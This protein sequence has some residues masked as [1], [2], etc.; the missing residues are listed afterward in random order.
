MSRKESGQTTVEFILILPILLLILFF[1][2]YFGLYCFATWGLNGIARDAA[3]IVSMGTMTAEVVK[4]D[5]DIKNNIKRYQLPW[6][7]W[8]NEADWITS[9][10]SK[11]TATISM[12]RKDDLGEFM[13]AII[14]DTLGASCVLP[15]EP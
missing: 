12:P 4:A 13:K 5:S 11:V 10:A 9:D 15:M 8:E 6:Y 7:D 14:P 2:A 3:R 1:G